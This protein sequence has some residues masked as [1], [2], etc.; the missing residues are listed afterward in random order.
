MEHVNPT[1]THA[2]VSQMVDQIIDAALDRVVVASSDDFEVTLELNTHPE[3]DPSTPW[4]W[5]LDVN[6]RRA[7]KDPQR[8]QCVNVAW[9]YA[10]TP[11]G[12]Y[13]DAKEQVSGVL[14]ALLAGQPLPVP[15][16]DPLYPD[17]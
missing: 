2:A 13:T 10:K 8:C 4:G 16:V 7:C 3:A 14:T 12:A 6:D 11:L 15:P 17:C 1:Y 5:E 9:G